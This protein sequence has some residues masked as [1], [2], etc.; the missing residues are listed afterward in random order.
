MNR[1]E[2]FSKRLV[3]SGAF[4]LTAMVAG[5]GGGDDDNGGAPPGGGGGGTPVDAAGAVCDPNVSAG[6][7]DLATA[8]TY[9]ILGQQGT[10]NNGTSAI[11]GNIGTS[12]AT[13]SQTTGFAE[14]ADA[15]NT[16]AT[17]SQVNGKMYASDYADPT[18]TNLSQAVGESIDA[19]VD[20]R[21]RTPAT[22]TNGGGDYGTQ[23]LGPGIYKSTGNVT[24]SSGDLTLTGTATDVFIFQVDGSLVQDAGR[25]V[26]LNGV[27]PKNVFWQVNTGTT[28]G[29]GAEFNGILITGSP[30]TLADTATM[31]G[32]IFSGGVVTLGDGVTLTR[33]E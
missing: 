29:A 31:K 2:I 22:S 25:K 17:S 7:V 16:F 4:L 21:D 26:V 9:V 18:P 3:W 23:T 13:A 12:P 6:C 30:V 19:Y 14:T 33:P 15:S 10:V 28:I 27:L 20:A 5:C 1:F 8:G 24:I 32:R 11:V